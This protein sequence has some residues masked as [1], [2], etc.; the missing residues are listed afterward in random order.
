MLDLRKESPEVYYLNHAQK[1][2]CLQDCKTLM[3][4]AANSQRNRA[5]FCAHEDK[6]SDI[7]E[8]FEVLTSDVYM[9]PHKQNNKCTSYHLVSGMV[10]VYLFDDDGQVID[11]IV[12]GE[13]HSGHEFYCRVPKNV[14]RMLV[15]KTDFV[16]YHEIRLGPFNKADTVFAPWAPAEDEQG[17]IENFILGLT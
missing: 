1:Y 17:D 5:R 14:Y 3:E 10:N 4:F 7:H 9:R 13:Y 8:M 6:D 12:L 15:P 16:L 11:C 2:L